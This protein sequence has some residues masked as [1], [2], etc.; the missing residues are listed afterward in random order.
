MG[1]RRNDVYGP[2]YERVSE[3]IFK[4]FTVHREHTLQFRVDIFNLLNTPSLG[5]PSDMTIASTGGTITSPRLFQKLTPDARFVQ[6][7]LKYSF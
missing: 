2:G 4:V 5:Q 6:L 1:G 3:S 7:S